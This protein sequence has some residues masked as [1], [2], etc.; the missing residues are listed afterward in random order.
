MGRSADAVDDYLSGIDGVF[1]EAMINREQALMNVAKEFQTEL[2]KIGADFQCD[3]VCVDGAQL[4]SCDISE[5]LAEVVSSCGCDFPIKFNAE[6]YF[7]VKPKGL[8]LVRCSVNQFNKIAC[9]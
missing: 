7:T 5:L 9:Y 2:A 6:E 1:N 3:Q 8:N 4:Y